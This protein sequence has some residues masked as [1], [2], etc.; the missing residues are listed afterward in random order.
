MAFLQKSG[1]PMDYDGAYGGECI[2]VVKYDLDMV[3]GWGR[4]GAIGN[5]NELWN[6]KYG[7]LKKM[8]F[9]KIIGTKD[10]QRGDIIFLNTGISFQHVWVFL[11]ERAHNVL[12]FDQVGNGDKVW[13]ELPP[14]YREWSK[15]IVLGV[16][17][18]KDAVL[19]PAIVFANKHNIRKRGKDEYFSCHDVLSILAKL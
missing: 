14:S 6:D 1:K 2:D 18:H 17:R 13:G 9:V 19:D 3:Y 11:E 5:A 12:I 8:W 10:M 16:W 7:I 15:S 4:I